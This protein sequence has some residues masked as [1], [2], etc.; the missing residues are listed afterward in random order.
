M[1]VSVNALQATGRDTLE[2]VEQAF[3]RLFI[4][5]DGGTC[6]RPCLAD[7]LGYSGGD[8]TARDGFGGNAERFREPARELTSP[9]R[10]TPWATQQPRSTA[11]SRKRSAFPPK[12][13]RAVSSPP[14]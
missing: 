5:P 14:E 9:Q 4:R 8:D 6:L 12:P 13:S 3:Q 2:V 10:R 11:G 1:E 7:A